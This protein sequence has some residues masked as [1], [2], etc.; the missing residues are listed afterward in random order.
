MERERER[1]RSAIE[2]LANPFFIYRRD[3]SRPYQLPGATGYKGN[4]DQGVILE[5]EL[6]PH[7]RS[8]SNTKVI[9]FIYV[10]MSSRNL[11]L[12]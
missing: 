11:S 8:V 10:Y 6:F 7:D 5:S 4:V 3:S 2:L 9:E 1:E 12:P